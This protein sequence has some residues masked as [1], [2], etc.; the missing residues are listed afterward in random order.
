MTKYYYVIGYIKPSCDGPCPTRHTYFEASTQEEY[1]EQFK[2]A[3]WHC[4]DWSVKE[5]TKDA[6]KQALHIE[7]LEKEH[8]HFHRWY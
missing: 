8:R 1:D 4:E 2:K 3:T 5:I 6:Y 7:Q